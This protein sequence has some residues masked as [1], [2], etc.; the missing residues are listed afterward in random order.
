MTLGGPGSRGTQRGEALTH[1]IPLA[2]SRASDNPLGAFPG[3]SFKFALGVW[4][5]FTKKLRLFDGSAWFPQANISDLVENL[6]FADFP[7]IYNFVCLLGSAGFRGV[8]PNN[9]NKFQENLNKSCVPGSAGFRLV[10]WTHNCRFP[11][12]PTILMFSW[13]R[14]VPRG[15]LGP[16]N[17]DFVEN[18]KCWF[19]GVPRDSPGSKITDFPADL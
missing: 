11:R 12:K 3:T 2:A 1:T 7:E 14:R 19:R 4:L 9:K 5:P 17:H 6:E 13:F 18:H 15:P 10:P 8:P 16:T